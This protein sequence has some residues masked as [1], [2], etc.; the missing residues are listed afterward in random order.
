MNSYYIDNA[1]LQTPLTSATYSVAISSSVSI[2]NY[3]S[4]S[5]ISIYPNPNNGTFTINNLNPKEE[6]QLEVKD[7]LGRTIYWIQL[8]SENGSEV[9][10]IIIE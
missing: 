5:N 9:Y 2:Q 10:K 6:Y 8:S 7:V 3:S 1:G 4:T